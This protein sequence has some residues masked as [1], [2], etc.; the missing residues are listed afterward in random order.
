M[1]IFFKITFSENS[2]SDYHILYNFDLLFWFV[3]RYNLSVRLATQFV[4]DLFNFSNVHT[5]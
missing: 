3:A 4:W 5:E 2:L 1:E